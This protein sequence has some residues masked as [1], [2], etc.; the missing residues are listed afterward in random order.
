MASLP[1][2]PPEG[3]QDLAHREALTRDPIRPEHYTKG[4]YEVIKVIQAWDL[5]D[6]ALLF[7][8]I[9][10]VARHKKKDPTK[11]LE[12]LKKAQQYLNWQIDLLEGKSL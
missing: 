1:P 10:Y 7:N 8:V 3:L 5:L 6:N 12:D 9:K 2:P 11:Q 4:P